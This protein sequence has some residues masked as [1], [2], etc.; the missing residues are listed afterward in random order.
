ML[1]IFWQPMAVLLLTPAEGWRPGDPSGHLVRPR[2]D[3]PYCC[4]NFF[5][6]TRVPPLKT[7]L[8]KS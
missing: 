4:D 6:L 5:W 3:Y 2:H 8:A 7:K 1:N